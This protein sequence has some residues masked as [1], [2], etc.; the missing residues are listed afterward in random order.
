MTSTADE[1]DGRDEQSPADDAGQR[2]AALE[3]QL[4]EK[5]R[6]ISDLERRERVTELLRQA[7]AVDLDA[8]RLLAETVIAE[9]DEP[10]VERAVEDLKRRKPAL[11]RS[12]TPRPAAQSQRDADTTPAHVTQAADAARAASMTGRRRDVMDY[13]RLRRRS[14]D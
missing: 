7:H 12:V 8:T 14:K 2:L 13:L 4:A 1:H 5:D 6:V 10:D 9:M 3:T 11:F